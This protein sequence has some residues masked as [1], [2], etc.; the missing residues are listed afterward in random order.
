[1]APTKKKKKP[2]DLEKMKRELMENQETIGI[3]KTLNI[4]LEAYVAQVLHFLANPNA[5][6]EVLLVEDDDL[7]ANGFEVPDADEMLKFAEDQ[8][9]V[10]EEA[11]EVSAYKK[12][13]KKKVDLGT[14][15]NTKGDDEVTSRG[16][17]ELKEDVE[18]ELRK[19]RGRKG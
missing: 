10:L 12:T 3:A 19:G 1:M 15:R 11:G 13:E 2:F 16:K 9:K 14:R 5:E 18:K 7:R 6:P 4:P 8:V 17:P